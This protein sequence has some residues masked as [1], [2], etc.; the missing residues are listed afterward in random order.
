M[1][2]NTLPFI[3]SAAVLFCGFVAASPSQAEEAPATGTIETPVT[4][5]QDGAEAGRVE[6]GQ[7]VT[8]LGLNDATGEVLIS[9]TAKDGEKIT[10]LVPGSAFVATTK[11]PATTP[12]PTPE[13][14]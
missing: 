14:D 4:V 2:K 7:V 11:E 10:G 13:S 3:F 9:F 12:A 8:I 6:A 1:I 5:F